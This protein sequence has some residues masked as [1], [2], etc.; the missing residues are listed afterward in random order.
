MTTTQVEQTL[1][2]PTY[3]GKRRHSEYV[4]FYFKDDGLTLERFPLINDL[5]DKCRLIVTRINKNKHGK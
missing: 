1:K 5:E 2:S 4:S 3:F